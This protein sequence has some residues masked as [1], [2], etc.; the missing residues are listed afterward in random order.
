L[1]PSHFILGQ[2]TGLIGTDVVSSTHNL[3]SHELFDEVLVF[4][5]FL[6]R[7]SKREHDGKRKT[8]RDSD[9]NNGNTGND[10]SEPL[11]NVSLDLTL[12]VVTKFNLRFNSDW[13][14]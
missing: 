2:G 13:S 12:A 9:Y 10:V 8:F 11:S 14:N 6:N 5:H 7:V 3:T 4:K 1:N